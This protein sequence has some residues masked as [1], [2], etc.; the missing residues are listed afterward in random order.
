M[1]TTRANAIEVETVLD[2]ILPVFDAVQPQQLNVTLTKLANALE[3]R[4]DELG[5]NLVNLDNY[6]RRFNTHL[7]SFTTDISELASVADSY[8]KA[9]PDLLR[10]L[11]NSAFT[12]HTVTTQQDALRQ[13][14]RDTASFADTATGFLTTN[15]ARLIQLGQVS[16]PILGELASR[17]TQISQTIDGLAAIAPKLREVFGTG[18]NKNWLHINLIPISPKGAYV[19]PND[20]PKY[21]NKEGSQYGPNCGVGSSATT[22]DTSAATVLSQLGPA[23]AVNSGTSADVVGSP[24]EQKLIASIVGAVTNQQAKTNFTDESVADLLLGPMLRG[25]T[26]TAP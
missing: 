9:A 11:A 25:T 21:I 24:A 6:L 19:A 3:G 18:T 7:P 15:Q 13:L 20:C 10:F 14:L 4:G 22:A 26:V 8:G 17:S 16:A 12:S 1:R 2:N 23:P 5:Q